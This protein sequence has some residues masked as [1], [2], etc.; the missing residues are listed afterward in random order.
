[1]EL[2]ETT[3]APVKKISDKVKRFTGDDIMRMSNAGPK[4]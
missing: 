1:M 2:V 4:W 3:K